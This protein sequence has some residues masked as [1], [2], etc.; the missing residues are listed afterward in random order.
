M[1]K[2]KFTRTDDDGD[3]I[4]ESKFAVQCY[5]MDPK[6][7]AERNRH[8]ADRDFDRLIKLCNFLTRASDDGSFL[9]RVEKVV[10]D[11]PSS[12]CIGTCGECRQS[13]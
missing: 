4:V 3:V 11:M 12:D 2:W 13:G 1:S 6:C 10:S 8:T 9:G 5:S 7:R